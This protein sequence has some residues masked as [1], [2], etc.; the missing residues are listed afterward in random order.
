MAQVHVIYKR[1]PFLPPD[2][3]YVLVDRKEVG[4]VMRDWFDWGFA[5]NGETFSYFGDSRRAVI[6]QW[7]ALNS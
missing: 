5:P 3:Y 7:L 4:V 2:F 1:S 6:D